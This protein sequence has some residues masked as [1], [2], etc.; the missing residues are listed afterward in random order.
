[1]NVVHLYLFGAVFCDNLLNGHGGLLEQVVHF[2]LLLLFCLT[3]FSLK[4]TTKMN[5]FILAFF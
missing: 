5:P 3:V 2:V 1:M 4:L